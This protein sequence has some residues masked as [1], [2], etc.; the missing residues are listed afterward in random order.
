[1]LTAFNEILRD[2]QYKRISVLVF[3]CFLSGCNTLMTP[4]TVTH[5]PYTL[6]PRNRVVCQ[7]NP[8]AQF[9][10]RSIPR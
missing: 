9:F 4:S 8:M 2:D 1:M 7:R 10:N 6:R 5:Q 3:A